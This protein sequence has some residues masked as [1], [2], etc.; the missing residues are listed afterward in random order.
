MR[1]TEI[2]RSE[3]TRVLGGRCGRSALGVEEGNR[4]EESCI[5]G[6]KTGLQEAGMGKAR[7]RWTG[8]RG[9]RTQDPRAL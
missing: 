3:S 9:A 7:S 5:P 2:V 4:L 6:G 8:R 1:T